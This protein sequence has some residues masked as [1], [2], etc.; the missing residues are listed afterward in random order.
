MKLFGTILS[1]LVAL[2][3]LAI[4]VGAFAAARMSSEQYGIPARDPSSL[5]DVRALGARD[6]VLG[7]IVIAFLIAKAR[8]PLSVVVALSALVGLADFLIV[9]SERGPEGARSLAIHG[10]G[11]VGLLVTWA[12]LR[13]GG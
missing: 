10:T 7:L 4:G 5:A 6:V 13:A 8:G 3:F 1:T 9:L 2:A 11:T 12:V